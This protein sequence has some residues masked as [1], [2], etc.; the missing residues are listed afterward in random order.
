[1]MN[2]LT[3]ASLLCAAFLVSGCGIDYGEA[4]QADFDAD[5]WMYASGNTALE[6]N[7]IFVDTLIATNTANAASSRLG[8]IVAIAMYDAGNGINQTN[9][10][11]F[12]TTPGDPTANYRAAVIS[13]AYTSLVALFPTRK[14]QLDASLANSLAELGTQGGGGDAL[15]AGLDYGQAVAQ[16]VLAWRATDGFNA[17]YPAFTGGT[18]VGQWRPIAPATS[19][20]G[21]NLAFTAPFAV[22]SNTQFRPAF[23][24]DLLSQDYTDDFNTVKAIGRKT[25][26]TRT[27]AYASPPR[28]PTWVGRR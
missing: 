15:Q 10:P 20:S 21:Q 23:P 14:T 9:T 17:S 28:S 22:D 27:P 1:M 12:Y 3:T 16:A 26:S 18:A 6:W 5:R 24:R 25:G 2:K 19:M 4:N 13:A 11:I 8:S 7:Q